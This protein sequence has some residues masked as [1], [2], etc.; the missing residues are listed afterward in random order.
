MPDCRTAGLPDC[1]TAG[2]PDCRTA[3]L[4][5][6]WTSGR[7][8]D[9]RTGRT[10]GRTVGQGGRRTERTGRRRGGQPDSRQADRRA[11]GGQA[12]GQAGGRWWMGR[13]V[14]KRAGRCR[15]A[16]PSGS[17]RHGRGWADAVL[18]WMSGPARKGRLMSNAGLMS[19]ARLMRKVGKAVRKGVWRRLPPVR[20]CRP[21]LRPE[22]AG[23][24][25]RP[26]REPWGNTGGP[27]RS[28]DVCRSGG[29]SPRCGPG[30]GGGR[31]PEPPHHSGR[32]GAERA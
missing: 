32:S 14:P 21:V 22:A 28:D 11:D 26:V 12:D 30:R 24:G 2:L 20:G 15:G 13:R 18:P 29:W 4:P 3:G 5:G 9:S 8:A 31:V 6:G 27:G 25:R 10:G 1:R 7:A 23:S 17:W 19:N 16:G